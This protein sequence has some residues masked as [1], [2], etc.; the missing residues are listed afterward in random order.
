MAQSNLLKTFVFLVL[1]IFSHEFL[2]IEGR[3]L[4]LKTS[5]RFLENETRKLA[6]NN[7]RS[8]VNDSLDKPV[9]ATKV[10]PPPAPPT[11]VAGDPQPSPRGRVDDFRPYCPGHS[12]GVGHS[13][14][15]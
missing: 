13:L 10:S 6:E 12:P 5:N 7:S 2:F 11:P 14:Q 1:I 4:K 3:H 15:N 8:H 9:D